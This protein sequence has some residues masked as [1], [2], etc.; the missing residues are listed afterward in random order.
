MSDFNKW[1]LS[2]EK[3]RQDI[4]KEDKWILAENAFNAGRTPPPGYK[5]VPVEPTN[6]DLRV[7]Q[8]RFSKLYG[9][10]LDKLRNAYIAM[11]SAAEDV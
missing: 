1:F 11:I 5:L 4:L 7:M 10:G 8:N 6:G 9:W 3:G 2:L